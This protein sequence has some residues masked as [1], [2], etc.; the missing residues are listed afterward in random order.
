MKT[1]ENISSEN[2]QFD[3]NDLSKGVYLVKVKGD[4]VYSTQK[5]IL[6]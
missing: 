2:Y 6:K 1:I 5:L 4:N 3:V